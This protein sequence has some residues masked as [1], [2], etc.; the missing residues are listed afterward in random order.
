MFSLNE[1]YLINIGLL[2]LGIKSWRQNIG[3]NKVNFN[4]LFSPI[5]TGIIILFC[6][7]FL[8]LL[9]FCITLSLLLCAI[10]KLTNKLVLRESIQLGGSIQSL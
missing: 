1:L 9:F 4:Y 2:Y 3:E 7:L 5:F 10:Y 8:S 6:L